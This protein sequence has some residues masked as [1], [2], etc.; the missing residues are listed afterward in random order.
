MFPLLPEEIERIIWKFFLLEMLSS[1]L[2]ILD[3]F[4]SNQVLELQNYVKIGVVSNL[5]IL[6]LKKYYSK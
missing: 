5:N 6:T 1:M 4:G 3:Q 2:K